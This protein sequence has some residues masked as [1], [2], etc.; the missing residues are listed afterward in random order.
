MLKDA[1]PEPSSG[2]R[3]YWIVSSVMILLAALYVVWIFY[4]RWQDNRALKEKAAAQRRAQDERTV[5]GMGGDRF[6]I[7]GFYA[8]QRAFIPEIPRT[9]AIAFQTQKR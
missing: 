8:N 3:N 9:F 1:T 2:F 4:S 6:E 7:L 5:Q